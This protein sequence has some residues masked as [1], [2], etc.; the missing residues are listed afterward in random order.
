MN[1]KGRFVNRRV[2][3]EQKVHSL[4]SVYHESS[5]AL[6]VCDCKRYGRRHDDE[7]CQQSLAE[8]WISRERV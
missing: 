6:G 4:F 2:E 5:K 7:K 1:R 8:E 3:T